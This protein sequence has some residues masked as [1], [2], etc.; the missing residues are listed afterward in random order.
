MLVTKKDGA[1]RFCVDYRKLN[2]ITRPDRHPLPCINDLLNSFGGATC[3]S[4][5]DLASGYWQV[6]M[7][8]RDREKTAFIVEDGVYEFNVMPFGL[9]NAPATFQ[10]MM[11]R[12]FAGVNGQFIVVY[13]DDLNVYSRDFN[14]HLKHLKEV[15]ERLRQ[16]GL[17]LKAKKCH[18]FK[19]ELAFLEHVVGADGVK[20]DPDKI[21]AVKDHSV[22]KD[23]RKLRQFVELAPYFF[24]CS[25]RSLLLIK[26]KES[27]NGLY[28]YYGIRL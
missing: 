25:I 20:P 8:P 19:K 22:P 21:A 28:T 6:E 3:F 18:F 23:I 15:F 2:K 26:I 9:T 12:V 16:A 7:D 1:I 11:N 10:R 14:E 27:G 13:L 4:T 24:F 5:L 17:R